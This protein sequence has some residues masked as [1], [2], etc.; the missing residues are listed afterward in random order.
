MLQPVECHRFSDL[1]QNAQPSHD[2]GCVIEVV[3]SEEILLKDELSAAVHRCPEWEVSGKEIVRVYEFETFA[4]VMD[5]VNTVAD[6]AES[7]FHH[8]DIDIRYTKVR[9]ALSTHELGGVTEADIE[10]AGRIDTLTD[11]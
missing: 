11:D 2:V 5:F 4:D 10:M 6:I 3:M 9:L 7:A 1:A 8:P